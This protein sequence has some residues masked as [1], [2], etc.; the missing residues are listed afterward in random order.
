M[1]IYS[2]FFLIY[3]IKF[4]FILFDPIQCKIKPNNSKQNLNLS[5]SWLN[6]FQEQCNYSDEQLFVI[7]ETNERIVFI[8]KIVI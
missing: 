6:V 5:Y 8:F 3:Q 2:S 7:K 4:E 1:Y